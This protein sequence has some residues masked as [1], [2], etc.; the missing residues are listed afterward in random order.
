MKLKLIFALLLLP[1][2]FTAISCTTVD[3]ASDNVT[4]PVVVETVQIEEEPEIVEEP[5]VQE[6]IEEEFVVTEEIYTE[7]FD[8][9]QD[10]ITNLNKVIAAKDYQVWLEYLTDEYK[11]YYSDPE[12]LKQYT[13]LYKQRGYNYR[14]ETLKDYFLYLVV[15]SRANAKLDEIVFIDKDH[16]KALSILKGQLSVLYYLEKDENIWK[17]GLKPEN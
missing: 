17:I 10:V 12:L 8:N 9:I 13:E 11:T 16:V 4:E 6:P 5:V 15:I 3:E 2:L 14:I 1:A 7:T